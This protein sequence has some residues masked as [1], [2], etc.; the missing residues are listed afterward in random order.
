MIKK[1]QTHLSLLTRVNVNGLENVS[2]LQ[3]F[4]EEV[5]EIKSKW[6][7][8]G[9]NSKQLKT[10]DV[11]IRWY[12]QNRSITWSGSK[13]KEYRRS[14][15]IPAKVSENTEPSKEDIA[16]LNLN[17]AE[18]KDGLGPAPSLLN[19]NESSLEK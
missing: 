4:V 15:E 3:L 18:D 13:A 19:I 10:E 1:L 16:S 6:T 11:S 8:P 7:A 17:Q 12:E 2:Q 14:L 9:G 5:L